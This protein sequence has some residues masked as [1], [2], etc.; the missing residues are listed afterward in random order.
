M[1]NYTVASSKES[2]FSCFRKHKVDFGLDYCLYKFDITT[3]TKDIKEDDPNKETL[4]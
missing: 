1:M 2:L 4:I 3:A